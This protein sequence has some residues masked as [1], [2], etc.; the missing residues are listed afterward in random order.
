MR[1]RKGSFN[2]GD[3]AG[4]EAAGTPPEEGGPSDGALAKDRRGECPAGAGTTSLQPP[5]ALHWG[6]LFRRWARTPGAQVVAD[7]HLGLRGQSG[8]QPWLR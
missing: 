2:V 5:S 6:H 4:A 7:L 3:N 1:A 8:P